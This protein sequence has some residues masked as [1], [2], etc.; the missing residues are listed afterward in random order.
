MPIAR[1]N[2]MNTLIVVIINRFKKFFLIKTSLGFSQSQTMRGRL[3]WGE[4]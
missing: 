1:I 3:L 4:V 2:A